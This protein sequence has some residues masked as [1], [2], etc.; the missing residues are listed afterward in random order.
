MSGLLV[1]NWAGLFAVFGQIFTAFKLNVNFLLSNVSGNHILFL[2]ENTFSNETWLVVRP[3]Q[4][5]IVCLGKEQ[6]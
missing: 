5:T 3:C 6:G 1:K 2:N 4:S